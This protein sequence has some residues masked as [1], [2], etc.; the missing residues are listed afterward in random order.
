MRFGIIGDTHGSIKEIG[1]PRK[2]F[3]QVQFL[4][5]TGDHWQDGLLIEKKWGI[6]VLA[7]KGNC[8]SGPVPS[9]FV[10]D[11]EDT[12]FFVTHGNNYGVKAGLQRLFYR[13]SEVGAHYCIF[14][15]THIPYCEKIET[16]VFL[17]PGSWTWPR[18]ERRYA[19]I[20][21]SLEEN[22]WQYQF[23]HY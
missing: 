13:A 5:H 21:L 22:S 17:N 11:I 12:R 14:G 8:D 4:V 2:I 20:L 6:P 3:S 10:F 15:H 18:S 1:D 19:G 23:I 7:V 9:E 16:I